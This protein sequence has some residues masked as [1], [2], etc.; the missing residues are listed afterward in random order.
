[1]LILNQFS[2]RVP[3]LLWSNLSRGRLFRITD[4]TMLRLTMTVRQMSLCSDRS[5]KKMNGI[6]ALTS[7]SFYRVLNQ[8]QTDGFTISNI[9]V[10]SFFIS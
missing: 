3:S 8:I 1:M 7:E 9:L 5:D 10:E 4:K 2:A 6:N